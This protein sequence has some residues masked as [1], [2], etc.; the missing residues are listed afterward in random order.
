M[1]KK[2]LNFEDSLAKLEGIVDALED[3][4][5]SLEESV[6]KFEEGIKLVKDCQRQLQEAELK[7]NK[8]MGDGEILDQEN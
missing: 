4:D 1:T 6:K 7:V 5:V 2:N 3:S 8:L